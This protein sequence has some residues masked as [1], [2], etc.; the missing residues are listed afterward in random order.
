L[1]VG[2]VLSLVQSWASIWLYDNPN[3][4]SWQR[5]FFAYPH[6]AW[7]DKTKSGW[8]RLRDG[9][10]RER[11][12]AQ[13]TYH[14][15]RQPFQVW[16]MGGRGET[17]VEL[18]EST[19]LIPAWA[20]DPAGIEQVVNPGDRWVVQSNGWPFRAWI[21]YSH[22]DASYSSLTHQFAIPNDQSSSINTWNNLVVFPYRPVFPGVLL[23]AVIFGGTLYTLLRVVR[24]FTSRLLRW[25]RQEAGLCPNCA[26]NARGLA[27][28]PECGEQL[29]KAATVQP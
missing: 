26:Y 3:T 2:L 20:F 22:S 16:Y 24:H 17:G 14:D 12:Y 10:P 1:I 15:D 28:C 18:T 8:V 27:V 19:D 29:S 23:N 6:F 4:P 25:R 11:V 13:V 21:G 5:H 9:D 7:R